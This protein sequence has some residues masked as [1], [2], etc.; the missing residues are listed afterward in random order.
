[1]MVS[2]YSV[3]KVHF[4]E[5]QSTL[6]GHHSRFASKIRSQQNN[7]SVVFKIIMT[8]L[9]VVLDSQGERLEKSF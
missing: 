4:R 9:H 6:V 2:A 1:M 8:L 5:I 3:L 7:G